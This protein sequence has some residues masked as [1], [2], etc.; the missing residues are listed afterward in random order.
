MSSFANPA[1]LADEVWGYSLD[2]FLR[3]MDWRFLRMFPRIVWIVD[4]KILEESRENQTSKN[5]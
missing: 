2:G 5:S 1:I 4:A 3:V